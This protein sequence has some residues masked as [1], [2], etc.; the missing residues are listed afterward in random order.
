MA[1]VCVY[2]KP[3]DNVFIIL[4]NFRVITPKYV[5][6]ASWRKIGYRTEDKTYGIKVKL[7]SRIHLMY[8]SF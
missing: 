1:V 3:K 2:F 8:F 4:Q 5:E 6:D 7:S